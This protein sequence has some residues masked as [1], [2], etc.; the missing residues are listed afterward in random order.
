MKP[1][2]ETID[3]ERKRQGKTKRFHEEPKDLSELMMKINQEIT[4][5]N[6][7]DPELFRWLYNEIS[8]WGDHNDKQLKQK[9]L[10]TILEFTPI[11]TKITGYRPPL[12]EIVRINQEKD[13]KKLIELAK[14][15]LFEITEEER[16]RVMEA[17]RKIL[18]SRIRGIKSRNRTFKKEILIDMILVAETWEQR[19]EI[20]K[21]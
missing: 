11:P 19:L 16:E 1:L 21:I 5:S 7:N 4:W 10:D 9:T 14:R 18:G 12:M 13:H 3:Y 15:D 20:A 6:S 2:L 8:W 17:G